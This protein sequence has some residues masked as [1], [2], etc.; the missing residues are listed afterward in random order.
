MIRCGRLLSGA[1]LGVLA[2]GAIVAP[3]RIV[4][5]TEAGLMH[6][7][8]LAEYQSTLSYWR[9][10]HPEAFGFEQRALTADSL[11]L[12]LLKITDH[13]VPDADK[14]VCLVTAMH[15]GPERSGTTACLAL[16]EWLLGEDVEAVETRK[17]QVVLIMPVMN[18]TA[19]FH[20]DRFRNAAGVD[21]YTGLGKLGKI[22]DVKTM[23]LKN[24]ADAPEIAALWSVLDEYRPEVH[25]DLHGTGLQEFDPNQLGARR[26]FDGQI[27]T[28][29][30]ASAYSNYI[31]RPWDWRVTEAMIAAGQEAGFGSDRFEADA[32]RLFWGPEVAPH[33]GRLWTGQPLFYSAHYGYFKYHTMIL[34]VETG[35]E[36]STV[37]RMRG[38]L[39]IGNSRWPDETAPG[40]PVNRI[41]NFVGSFVTAEGATAAER[42]AS[43]VELWDKQQALSLGFLYPQMDGR[44]SLVCAISSQARQAVQGDLA[45]FGGRIAPWIGEEAA[46]N[47]QAFVHAG[48]EIKLAMDAGVSLPA[49]PKVTGFDHGIGFRLRLPYRDVRKLDVHLNGRALKPDGRDGY[50][51]WQADG[52]TQ[53]QVHVPAERTTEQGLFVITCAYQPPIR[54]QTGWMPPPAVR[55]ELNSDLADAL[56]PTLAEVPYGAHFRQTMD[57][58]RAKREDPAPLVVFIHGGGWA[59]DDKTEVYHRFD[60]KRMLDAGVS[61]ASIDYRFTSDASGAGVTPPVQ[62]PMD[63]CAA[64]LQ[65]IVSKAEEWGLD[66]SRLAT[67]GVSA[68]GCAALWLAMRDHD[69][70]LAPIKCAAAIAPQT[71]LDPLELREW[72]PNF[73]RLGDAFGFRTDGKDRDAEF[74]RFFEARAQMLPWIRRYSP[75][76][77]ASKDDPPLFLDF[78]RQQKL[79]VKGESQDDAIHSALMG[80]MLKE[81]LQPLGVEVQIHG[82]AFPETTD[83]SLEAFLIRELGGG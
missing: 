24:P 33:A 42:R 11:P 74:Q 44:A 27:M 53:L 19:L 77:H 3:D 25:A 12:Y 5:E 62:W 39:R 71:S 17:K 70:P 1:I 82:P 29:I 34:A 4:A 56:P 28:E 50:E 57:F 6:R 80:T 79:P 60:L 46:R 7:L 32:Q 73:F 52:F 68:G 58:W 2:V 23:T 63:D 65:F 14:Q 22:I 26:M 47:V 37:A 31:L 30:T 67:C 21:P 81:R 83:P 59:G 69:A 72:M 75:I 66:T 48:P 43:R 35:W 16:A 20:T 45:G 13:K 8:T 18:P 38:L 78:P 55:Q 51:V 49:D 76:A 10:Q 36:A 54:R 9:K 64:G 40:Y 41:K 61:I 15:S